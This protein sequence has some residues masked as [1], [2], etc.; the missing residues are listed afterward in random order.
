M[1]TLVFPELLTFVLPHL[2]V[3]LADN[4]PDKSEHP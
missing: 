1:A 2:I 3:Q 4:P